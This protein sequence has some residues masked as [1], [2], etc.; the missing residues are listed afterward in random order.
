MTGRVPQ[1]GVDPLHRYKPHKH[2]VKRWLNPLQKPLQTVTR[3]V[4][5]N[6]LMMSVRSYYGLVNV[7]NT[8]G[9]RKQ[10]ESRLEGVPS[11]F[12]K[13]VTSGLG[14]ELVLS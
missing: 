4:T 5:K 7:I 14:Q 13:S 9:D 12:Y 3:P 1:G 8:I 10:Q 11:G 6:H 2:W